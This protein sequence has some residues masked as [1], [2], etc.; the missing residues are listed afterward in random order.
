MLRGTAMFM[1]IGLAI[2]IVPLM[3]LLLTYFEIWPERVIGAVWGD[4][5]RL[6]EFDPEKESEG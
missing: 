4:P 2:F 5:A 1:M 3:A 6:S